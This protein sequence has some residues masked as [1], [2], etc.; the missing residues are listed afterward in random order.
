MGFGLSNNVLPFFPICYQLPPSSHSQ[1]LNISFF[2]LFPSFPGLT[3]LLVPSSSW[4]KIFLGILSSSTLSRWPNQLIFSPFIH[5]TM[6]SPLLIASSSRFVRLFHSPF[7]YLGPYII[8]NIFFSKISRACSSFVV[9]A[10]SLYWPK[11]HK[12]LKATS[13]TAA[14]TKHASTTF[15][16]WHAECRLHLILHTK[17]TH[18]Q[19]P[20]LEMLFC[21][22]W[23][24][25][26]KLLLYQHQHNPYLPK[27]DRWA[28]GGWFLPAV[29]GML[30]KPKRQDGG[31]AQSVQYVLHD[32][33]IMV[34]F[35]ARQ[36]K[37]TFSC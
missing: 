8:L 16:S 25:Y 2:F 14:A 12:F 28:Y 15:G 20:P 29:C 22:N 4:V 36:R 17:Y 24:L 5:L 18:I 32:R 1:H 31:K 34:R 27:G 6:S 23:S 30:H 13:T 35:P 10:Y 26:G 3:L 33:G 19:T 37:W 11:S 9:S 7:S 21:Y